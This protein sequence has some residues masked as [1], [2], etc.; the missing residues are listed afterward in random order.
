MEEMPSNTPISESRPG[1][2]GWVQTWIMA[3][4]KPNEQT[5][6]D[7][8]ESTNA[9]T[10]TA[11]IWAVIAGFVSGIAIGITSALQLLIQSGDAGSMDAGTIAALVCGLPIAMAIF[12]PI[13]LA[14][15]TALIQWVAKLFGG[16]GSFEKLIYPIS[17]IALPMTI[18][19]GVVSVLSSIPIVGVC[20]S[21]FSFAVSVYAIVLNVLAVKAVNRFDSGKAIASVLIPGF[22][23]GIVFVCCIAGSLV[24]LGPVIGDTFNQINQGLAP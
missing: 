5:F 2:A 19:S 15:S 20:I 11:L 24:I 14:I 17:A 21:I 6:I 22:V 4:T 8:S 1:P 7:I 12:N 16:T 18:I 23:I 3:V 13:G 9:K 10:Q